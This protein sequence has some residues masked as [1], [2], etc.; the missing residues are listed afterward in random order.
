MEYAIEEKKDKTIL[1]V[2]D[3]VPLFFRMNDDRDYRIRASVDGKAYYFTAISTDCPFASV[4]L[5]LHSNTNNGT[6]FTIEISF[7]KGH[8][9]KFLDSTQHPL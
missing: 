9:I 1:R 7:A 6:N 5:I 2:S 3:S 8:E 4:A